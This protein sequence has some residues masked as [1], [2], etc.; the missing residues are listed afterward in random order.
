MGIFN[1]LFKG[2]D[3]GIRIGAPCD[4]K[5]VPLSAVSDP[6]FAEEILGKGVAIKPEG[7]QIKSPCDGTVDLMFDTGHAVNLKSDDGVELLIH[8][9][10][11]T[12]ALKGEGFKTFKENDAKVK[13]G[14]LLIE[15]DP[16]FLTSRG[17]ELIV[18]MIVCNTD[19]YASVKGLA[20]E[21]VKTGDDVI[22]ITKE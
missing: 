15:F 8:I 10:I 18:P 14:D 17:Y 13:K 6:T 19:E 11:D 2:K 7:N 22:V 5:T 12:V 16:E 20:G 1:K 9:G 4:G 21:D 3:E